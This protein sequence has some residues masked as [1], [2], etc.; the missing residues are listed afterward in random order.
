MVRSEWRF[1]PSALRQC[2][3]NWTGF[4]RCWGLLI[5]DEEDFVPGPK[6]RRKVLLYTQKGTY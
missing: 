3:A 4:P 2:A 5:F 1:A 6:S